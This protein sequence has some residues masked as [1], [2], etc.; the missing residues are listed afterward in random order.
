[1][2]TKLHQDIGGCHSIAIMTKHT[3]YLGEKHWYF[4][5]KEIGQKLFHKEY[6]FEGT[7][8]IKIVW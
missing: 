4:F 2:N 1:M 5:K 6:S 3:D 7:I 8:L